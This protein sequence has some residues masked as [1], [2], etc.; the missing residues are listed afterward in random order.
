[1]INVDHLPFSSV[2]L[3][4]YTQ[5]NTLCWCILHDYI[6]IHI[7]QLLC[8]SLRINLRKSLS[9]VYF[10]WL[11]LHQTA[12]VFGLRSKM[13]CFGRALSWLNLIHPRKAQVSTSCTTKTMPRT[14]ILIQFWCQW[15][16]F[17]LSWCF[18]LLYV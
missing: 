18:H 4:A 12:W 16:S 2:S 5:L 3:S 7:F 13:K 6:K 11:N 10:T 1:M 9:S 14:F 8:C 15:L 17:A